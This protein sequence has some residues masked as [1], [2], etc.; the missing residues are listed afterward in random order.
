MELG[1][2]ANSPEKRI[3]FLWCLF[4]SCSNPLRKTQTHFSAV[5]ETERTGHHIS[6]VHFEG[7]VDHKYIRW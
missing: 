5:G 6:F 4:P 3:D 2:S 7:H 1:R